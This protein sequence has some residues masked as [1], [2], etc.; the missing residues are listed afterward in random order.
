MRWTFT[1]EK[2]ARLFSAAALVVG[3]GVVPA[4]Q[5]NAA[6]PCYNCPPPC[7]SYDGQMQ[8]GMQQGLPP[9]ENGAAADGQQDATDRNE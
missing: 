6:R 9:G 3:L 1:V 5:A 7:Y 2:L 4:T 8:Q